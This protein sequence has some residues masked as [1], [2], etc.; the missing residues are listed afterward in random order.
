MNVV[1]RSNTASLRPATNAGPLGVVLA[2]GIVG[3][4]LASAAPA[5]AHKSGHHG[6]PPQNQGPIGPLPKPQPPI[7]DGGW[8]ATPKPAQVRDHRGGAGSTVTVT[9]GKARPR[10]GVQCLGNMCGVGKTVKRT[11]G[12]VVKT[13]KNVKNVIL[14]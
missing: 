12:T 3:A 13:V 11:I 4:L 8:H 9:D 2:L 10:G 6:K 1:T 7:I 5:A 14:H